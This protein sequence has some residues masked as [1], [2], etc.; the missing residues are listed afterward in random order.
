MG[1]VEKRALK[2]LAFLKGKGRQR[3]LW[4]PLALEKKP[5][6]DLSHNDYLNLNGMKNHQKAMLL[7]ASSQ[8]MGAKASRL[9]GKEHELFC[10]LEE[11]FA[12][13]KGAKAALF[14]GAGYA[15]NEALMAALSHKEVCFFLDELCHASLIEGMRHSPLPRA[16]KRVF[17]H[18]DLNAL[19]NM[20]KENK[21]RGLTN[22]IVTE[23]LFS[24]DGDFAPIEGILRLARLYNGFLVLDEAHSIG[25]LGASGAGLLQELGISHKDIITINPCGKAMGA[26]GAFI[27]GPLWLKEYMVSTS[28]KFIYSTAPSPWV[29]RGLQVSLPV[30]A[31][32]TEERRV[33][34]AKARKLKKALCQLGYETGGSE[35]HIIPVVLGSE[36]QAVES[37]AFLAAKG[38]YVAAV[39]PPTV[40]AGTSR[41]RL[42]VHLG[43]CEEEMQQVILAFKALKEADL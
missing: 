20:L 40:P 4:R 28:R 43:I 2:R 9:L 26:Q 19:E 39:R 16:L 30:V 32:M 21:E 41:L 11:D 33:L 1:Q 34:R 35:S 12:A 31:K 17:P 10:A 25:A 5:A 22:I 18:N 15:A 14:F 8:T 24:M 38:V 37:A 13:F 3:R 29:A 6:I 7:A 27:C 23:A 36:K 42:S